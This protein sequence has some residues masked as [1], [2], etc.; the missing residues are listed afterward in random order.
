[1]AKRSEERVIQAEMAFV[2]EGRTLREIADTLNSTI[3]TITKWCEEGNWK[4]KR[5]RHILSSGGLASMLEQQL[6]KLTLEALA[7]QRPIT[8]SDANTILKLSKAIQELRGD[9]ASIV[10]VFSV[11]QDLILFLK[12]A[13][14]DLVP[15]LEPHVES[16]LQ[17]KRRLALRGA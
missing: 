10:Q 11:I 3:P 5:E 14:P 9:K 13:A 2:Q 7:N 1:M 6:R 15:T 16:F 12:G 8:G 4:Q 17:A